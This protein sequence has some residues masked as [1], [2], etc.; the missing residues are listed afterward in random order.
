MAQRTIEYLIPDKDTS[1]V[2]TMV[3]PIEVYLINDSP[4][5]M[6]GDL[7]G[8]V[9]AE[10][11]V[12]RPV[13]GV[14]C[15]LRSQY[16]RQVTDCASGSVVFSGL[17]AGLYVLKIHAHN[18]KADLGV[19]KRGF[20]VT[21]DPTYCSLVLINRGVTISESG[22]EVTV[23]VKGHGTATGYSCVLDTELEFSCSP[24]T[25]QLSVD[26][27]SGGRHTLTITPQ[28]CAGANK[29]LS[30]PFKT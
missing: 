20:V 4:H 23:E 7:P 10:F 3:P 22:R 12:S 14:R 18:R 28:G 5:V 8:S 11:R 15:Y 26:Q 6:S 1:N 2:E 29:T 27:L 25:V 24:P 13:A 21:S 16:D 30:V 19:V 9:M 17:Q